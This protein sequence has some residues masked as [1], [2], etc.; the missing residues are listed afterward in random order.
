[1]RKI[2]EL[3]EELEASKKIVEVQIAQVSGRL[4][5]WEKE[6]WVMA[7]ELGASLSKF[8]TVEFSREKVE[9]TWKAIG[10]LGVD[11]ASELR[12][13]IEALEGFTRFTDKVDGLKIVEEYEEEDEVEE[14]VEMAIRLEVEMWRPVVQ[15]MEVMGRVGM[16]VGYVNGVRDFVEA[17]MKESRELEEVRTR[18]LESLEKKM[19]LDQ[20]EEKEEK[21][22]T[23]AEVR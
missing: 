2:E 13:L 12:E 14:L 3:K 22:F 5:R 6:G 21:G 16:V 1:M 17:W 7:R 10:K 19:E 4:S 8:G 9:E 20:G 23:G 15:V 11:V 18:L